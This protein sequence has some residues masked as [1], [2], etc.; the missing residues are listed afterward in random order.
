MPL[1]HLKDLA[2]SVYPTRKKTLPKEQKQKKENR[3]QLYLPPLN[4][5]N[6]SLRH[7]AV[8]DILLDGNCHHLWSGRAF[9]LLP[10]NNTQNVRKY[11]RHCQ[12]VQ[13]P[14]RDLLIE[15]NKSGRKEG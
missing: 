2:R 11:K 8:A 13:V 1:T 12:Q 15:Y 5:R 10:V 9:G 14:L 7:E 6:M 4:Q 3:E